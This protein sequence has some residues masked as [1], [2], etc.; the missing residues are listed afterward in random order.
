MSFK[1]PERK[2]TATPRIA[3]QDFE[4]APQSTRQLAK[5]IRVSLDLDPDTHKH[6]KLEAIEKGVTLAALLREKIAASA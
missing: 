4:E 1:L 6:L 3:K 2:P 5:P